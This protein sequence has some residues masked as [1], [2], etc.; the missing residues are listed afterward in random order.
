MKKLQPL[1]LIVMAIACTSVEKENSVPSVQRLDSTEITH[2]KL[3]ER[4]ETLMDSGKVAGLSVTIFNENTIAYSKAF[5]WANV[6]KKDS[7]NTDMIVYGASFSKAVF[8]YLVSQLAV[9]GII[10]L[11]K[12]IQEYLDKPLPEIKFAKEWRGF[13]N[14]KDDK[15]YEQITARMC[16]A[17][18]TGLPN[19]RWISKDGVFNPEGKI[20]F[21]FDPGTRYSYSGEGMTL[22][23]H[24]IEKITNKGL[25]ELARERIFD[26]LKMDM[27]SYVWQERFKG[28]F[29]YGH[30][31]EG[32]V[33]PKD[34]EDEANA[35]GSMETTFADYNKF[36][37]HI[38][39]Q[40]QANSSVIAEMLKSSSVNIKSK[41]QFG[42]LAWE[43]ST[44]HDHINLRYGLGWGLMDTPHGIAAFKEGHGEGFQ[45][46][47][48]MFPEKKIG[49]ILMS[50]SDN[51]ESI[52]KYLLEE[53]I[54][55]VY[56]SWEWENY[57]PYD[58]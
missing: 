22:L 11:D 19:W 12:P 47:S 33:I 25:E 57:I 54:G 24:A 45:H 5:G 8:G 38:M 28:K 9:E 32:K 46:Y 10:D 53:T 41:M 17:H 29:C 51:G 43:D 2:Q 26:P 49:L 36:F 4:I 14:L 16:L 34:T 56:T 58:Y 6:D 52:F 7:L 3:T 21:Y 40:H 39:E 37:K 35:A 27:T 20:K 1:L 15:R 23:Q 13:A 30:T 44:L 50:N 18:T 55:D 48:I 31:V 42:P